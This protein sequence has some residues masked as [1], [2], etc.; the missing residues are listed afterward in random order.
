MAKQ[1]EYLT[2]RTVQELYDAHKQG[3][4]DMHGHFER[5]EKFDGTFNEF[6]N[7][8]GKE[9]WEFFPNNS[10]VFGKREIPQERHNSYSESI[11]R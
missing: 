5:L 6:I 9:G 10:G 7:K 1:F 4:T 11:S 8:L 2:S 3:Y